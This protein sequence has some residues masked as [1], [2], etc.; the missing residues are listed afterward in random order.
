M[1][2]TPS[3][4]PGG[5][6]RHLA[7]R[8]YQ[9]VVNF[10]FVDRPGSAT[11]APTGTRSA[12]QPD[13]QPPQ[14]DATSLIP[15]RSARSPPT[16]SARSTACAFSRWRVFER[17]PM[18]SRCAASQVMNIAALAHRRVVPE[19]W[20]E[21]ARP[22]DF[23]RREGRSRGAVR[24]ARAQFAPLSH[25]ALHPGRGRRA[26]SLDGHMIGVLGELHP[27]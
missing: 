13:R 9:E 11:S 1:L 10:A 14:R 23:L 6:L 19:Q 3:R 16:A 4:T 22:V 12:G 8:G 27:V 25:P 5:A 15:G 24:A 2:P 7:A 17:N 21:R 18:A 20:G 26:F